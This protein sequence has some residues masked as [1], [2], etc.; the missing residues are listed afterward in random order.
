MGE[1]VLAQNVAQG[2]R[3]KSGERGLRTTG[4]RDHRGKSRNW[5]RGEGTRACAQVAAAG[6]PVPCPAVTWRAWVGGC[7]V[8]RAGWELCVDADLRLLQ[9]AAVVAPV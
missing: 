8:D 9:S 4:P 7:V 3:A 2:K 6:A 5:N 1:D